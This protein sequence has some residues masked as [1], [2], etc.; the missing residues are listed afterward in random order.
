VD[1]GPAD[2]AA[3]PGGD[4]D[5][6]DADFVWDTTGVAS[7]LYYICIEATTQHGAA[8]HCSDAPVQVE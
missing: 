6:E 8:I 3:N 4:R 2:E 1:G 5:V 7:G